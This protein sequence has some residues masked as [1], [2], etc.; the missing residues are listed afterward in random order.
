MT[1]WELI[2]VVILIFESITKR[3][4]TYRFLVKNGKKLSG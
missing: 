1:T 4:R 2:H 3:Q